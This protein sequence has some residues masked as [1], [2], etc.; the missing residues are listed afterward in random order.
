MTEEVIDRLYLGRFDKRQENFRKHYL[1]YHRK[2]DKPHMSDS[3][4]N[5]YARLLISS[6][7]E[8]KMFRPYF[9]IADILNFDLSGTLD[10]HP[11]NDGINPW[12][13]IVPMACAEDIEKITV[14]KTQSVSLQIINAFIDLLKMMR[15]KL[16]AHGSDADLVYNVNDCI[17]RLKELRKFIRVI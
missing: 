16:K 1:E 10:V 12:K 5:A 6:E 4:L 7:K 17:A 8:I 15:H 14:S 9:N 2:V 13:M 3:T 11:K